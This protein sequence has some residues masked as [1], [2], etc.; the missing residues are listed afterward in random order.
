MRKFFSLSIK[1]IA[2]LLALAIVAVVV[3]IIVGVTVDL[4]FLRPG[5][6]KAAATALGREVKTLLSERRDPGRYTVQWNGTNHAG[7]PVASGVYFARLKDSTS[8]R[9]SKMVL[10]K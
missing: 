5:V 3:C 6:E 7:Q 9:T 4:S 2:G 1:I 10:A 8:Q